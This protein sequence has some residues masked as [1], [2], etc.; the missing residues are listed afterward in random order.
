MKSAICILAL[1][2]LQGWAV[3]VTFRVDLSIQ[4]ILDRYDPAEDTVELRGAFNGWGGGTIMT[5]E[6]G[7]GF[8]FRADFDILDPPGST[9]PYKF[10]IAAP[11]GTITWE[12][13]VGETESNRTF[14][15]EEGGQ[16]LPL[17]YFDNLSV[18]PGAGV[19]VTFQVDLA[20]R[21]QAGTFVPGVDIIEARGPFN[22]WAGGFVL[23]QLEAE[24]TIYK[25][26]VVINSILPGNLVPYKYIINGAEWETGDNRTFTLEDSAQV[27]PVRYFDD[28]EPVEPIVLGPIYISRAEGGSVTV[29]WENPE[30]VLQGSTDLTPDTWDDIP[31]SIGQLQMT[32]STELAGDL[33]FRLAEP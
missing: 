13:D 15:L 8:V 12:G 5:A 9:I 21:I 28:L 24:S 25:G 14:I 3:P 19:E 26:S 29:S 33:Y 22:S 17:V 18:D 4:D 2:V 7:G 6:Q 11:D 20:A 27:L 10:V 30:V 32:F 16:E 1:S 31:G 23:E